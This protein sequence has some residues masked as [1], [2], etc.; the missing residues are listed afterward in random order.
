MEMGGQYH[1]LAS[2]APV[3]KPSSHLKEAG[4][5]PGSVWICMEKRNF[6]PPPWFDPQTDQHIASHYIINYAILALHKLTNK[7]CLKQTDALCQT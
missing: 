6:L 3:N 2:S 7:K 1:A 5:A 4:C